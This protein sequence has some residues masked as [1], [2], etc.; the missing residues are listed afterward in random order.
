[1]RRTTK[2]LLVC[3]LLYSCASS[4]TSYKQIVS[5]AFN[6]LIN[7][8]KNTPPL[9]R[10]GTEYEII[11]YEAV[12]ELTQRAELELRSGNSLEALKLLTIAKEY[13]SYHG[14]VQ[15]LYSLALSKA[16]QATISIS[17]IKGSCTTSEK[18]VRF[19]EELTPDSLS[20]FS[21]IIESCKINLKTT[22]E[23]LP[24]KEKIEL[25][26]II[27]IAKTKSPPINPIDQTSIDQELLDVLNQAQNFPIDKML[28]IDLR[29]FSQV[30]FV[31]TKVTIDP[32]PEDEEHIGVYVHVRMNF[33]DSFKRDYCSEYKELLD[34]PQYTNSIDCFDYESI[35][36]WGA[37][38]SERID[39]AS[40]TP[41]HVSKLF[42]KR[43]DKLPITKAYPEYIKLTFEYKDG[44]KKII[45]SVVKTPGGFAEWTDPNKGLLF[46]LSSLADYQ[47]FFTKTKDSNLV[48]QQPPIFESDDKSQPNFK[49]IFNSKTSI[50]QTIDLNNRKYSKTENFNS[51]L[52][53]FKDQDTPYLLY[54]SL[55]KNEILGLTGVSI[56]FNI[57]KMIEE[58]E[59][60][61]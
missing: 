4:K 39:R 43:L 35:F 7:Y 2:L 23:N 40:I 5:P 49:L 44:T 33:P 3:L 20:S 37:T 22:K 18:R 10:N 16:I 45:S 60:K 57:E 31:S 26:K 30:D 14:R 36:K 55:K 1:M 21:E 53:L 38:Q 34:N 48:K 11:R 25:S 12:I 51:L 24:P 61:H 41:I 17:K 46:K 29:K 54:I 8:E 9:E 56:D 27:K 42:F 59:K 6:K 28:L 19:L 32:D 15:T 52:D 50:Q 13:A 58:I 47:S